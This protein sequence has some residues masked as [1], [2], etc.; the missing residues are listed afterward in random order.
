MIAGQRL[1][2]LLRRGEIEAMWSAFHQ[3]VSDPLAQ[4]AQA[5]GRLRRCGCVPLS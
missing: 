2:P 3:R 4:A 5:G 1:V